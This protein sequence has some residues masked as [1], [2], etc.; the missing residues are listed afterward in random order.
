MLT[1][2]GHWVWDFW[3]A[4]DGERFHCFYLHAPTSLGDPERRHRAAR[5]GHAVSEDLSQWTLL[6]QLFEA[7]EPGSFDEGATWTGCT[8]RG[9]DGLWR[10]FYTGARFLHP[11]PVH[12]NIETVGVAVS[13]DLIHWDKRPG[14][15]TRADSR[16]YETLGSSAWP[17]EAWRDP[18]VFRDPSGQGWH[19]LVTARAN[20]GELLDR[21]V[22]G[23][24]TS[25][26]LDTWQVQPPL[27]APGSGFGHMEVPQVAQMDGQ[28]TL[29]F[30]C[31]STLLA[32]TNPARTA[33]PGTWTLPIE[34]PIGPYPV[35]RARPLTTHE[36]YSG[37]VAQQRDRSW[38]LLAFHNPP[39]D[40]PFSG[41]VSD[42]LPLH[43]AVDGHPRLSVPV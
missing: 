16:W 25:P 33:D 19:M 7:G 43:A 12:T 30:S 34:G 1:H 28:W 8:V 24:A 39:P 13:T 14:P 41:G 2:P 32:R 40:I 35:H 20:T 6:P 10:T 29:L 27:S 3:L 9:D 31:G 4:D 42:P 23:H 17:E 18:W 36:L 38:A 37:R 21:G 22:I 11:E 5:I 15:V 26:D